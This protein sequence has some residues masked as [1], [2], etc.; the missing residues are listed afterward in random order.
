MSAPV[1]INLLGRFAFGGRLIG[2]TSDFESENLGSRPSPQAILNNLPSLR[3]I[4]FQS[5]RDRCLCCVSIH[6]RN[7]S[8]QSF[9]ALVLTGATGW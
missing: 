6:F 2:R 4:S 3:L 7:S 1:G 8:L 9:R 5:F